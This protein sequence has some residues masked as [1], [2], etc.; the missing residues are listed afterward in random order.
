MET[1]T[2][3]NRTYY[4]VQDSDRDVNLLLDPDHQVSVSYNTDEPTPGVSV[5]DS[6]EELATYL[7]QT[8]IPF[9]P[10]WVVVAVEGD[11]AEH[12]DE[13]HALGARLIYPDRIVA[14]ECIVESG[15]LDM[16]A[17]EYDALAA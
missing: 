3:S 16:I 12:R 13:D 6:P 14:V 5:C 8:G 10:S 7:A 4:R 17:A 9:D 2:H 15:M 1:T 11:Q